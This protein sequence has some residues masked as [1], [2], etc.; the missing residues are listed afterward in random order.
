MIIKC[1][2]ELILSFHYQFGS[3]TFLIF[4]LYSLFSGI[5][6]ICKSLFKNILCVGGWLS[7][8]R[9]VNVYYIALYT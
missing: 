1:D 8:V 7:P 4:D 9:D 6:Q 2:I 3:E 5:Q